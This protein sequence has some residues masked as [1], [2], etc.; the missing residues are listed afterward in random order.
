[1]YH[2]SLDVLIQRHFCKFLLVNKYDLAGSWLGFLGDINFSGELFL[3]K[4]DI[5]ITKN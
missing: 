1:M 5:S 3:S 2:Q 4:L